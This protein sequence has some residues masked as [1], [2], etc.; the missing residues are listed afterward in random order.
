MLMKN[1]V[2]IDLETTGLSPARDDIVELSAVRFRNFKPADIYSTLVYP[3]NGIKYYASKVNGITADMV[4]DAPY[5]E[6]VADEFIEF[7]SKD[8]IVVGQNID[9]DLRFLSSNGIEISPRSHDIYDTM[10][11]ARRHLCG[12]EVQNHKLDTLCRYY[13]IVNTDAHRGVGDCKATG[14]LFAKLTQEMPPR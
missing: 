14:K 13:K 2:V 12:G 6:D 1:Y 7:V 3:E 10:H 9:F 11:M 4:A 5:I 8:R